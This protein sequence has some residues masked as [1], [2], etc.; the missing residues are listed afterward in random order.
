MTTIITRLYAD[1]ATA[2]L[3][4]GKLAAAG[5]PASAMDIIT[6]QG[7][8]GAIRAAR[9]SATTAAS[10]AAAVANGHALLVARAPFNPIGAARTVTEIMDETPSIKVGL[11]RE[12]E[13]VRETIK[14][15]YWSSILK[16]HPRFF[17]QDLAAIDSRL[18]GR[19][20]DAFG[21]RTLLRN[22]N[23]TSAV[24]RSRH[25]LPGVKVF[26]PRERTSA[27]RGGMRISDLIGWRTIS[28]RD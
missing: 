3:V 2:S 23:K 27:I 13:Y 16:D 28:L 6:G 20:S 12:S 5:F 21:F 11:A 24:G 10:Y 17:S 9:A 4:A 8:E 15:Q 22:V 14:P 19:V 18:R 1:H 25:M 7:G 26:T